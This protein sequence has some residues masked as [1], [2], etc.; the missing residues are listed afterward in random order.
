MRRDRKL[1]LIYALCATL[2]FAMAGADVS[3]AQSGGM[4][5]PAIDPPGEPFSYFWHPNDTIGA[6]F[7]P[8]ATEVT[9]EGYLYTGFGELIFFVGNPIE[10]V[11]KRIKTLYKGYLPIVQY[12]FPF[13]G[14]QYQFRMF[15]ADLGAGLTGLPVNFIEVKLTN[16]TH[17]Q[18]AAFLTSAFRFMPP[19]RGLNDI[20]EY[21]F[22]QRFDFIPEKY[23]KGQS[24]FSPE[25]KYSF[26]NNAVVRD[27]RILYLF[28]TSPKPHQ[29]A[30]APDDTGLRALRYFTGQ[31][32]DNPN[33][34]YTVHPY[35]P[36]GLVMY[37]IRLNPG[38]SQSLTFKF[39]IVPLPQDS[40][41]AEQVKSA[42][43]EQQ[44]QKTVQVWDNLVAKSVPLR[45]PE[46]KVQEYLLANTVNDIFA[47]DK[48]GD[49]FIPTDNKFQYH[50]S[51]AG[52][53]TNFM[54]IGFDY[55]GLHDIARNDLLYS[56]KMQNSEGAFV[57]PDGLKPGSQLD[58]WDS[59]G[60]TLFGWGRHYM[61]TRDDDFLRRVYPAVLRAFEW[62][63]K[64]VQKD[65][66]GLMPPATITDDAMLKDARQTGH[67]LWTMIGLRNAVRMAEAMTKPED[68][69]RFDAEYQRLRAAFDKQLALQTAKSGGYIPP[70][71]E[72]TLD[73]NDWDNMLLLHPEPL[74]EPF[75]P[76]VT[77]TLRKTRSTYAEGILDYLTQWAVA[78]E[79]W[80][81]DLG[82]MAE[83]A[84]RGQGYIFNNR[85]VLHY[86]HTPTNAGNHL[87]RGSAEDQELAVRDMYSMLLHSTSTHASQEFGSVPWSTRDNGGYNLLPDVPSS[88]K[89][90]DL[91]RNMLVREYK[92][93]LYLLSALSPSWFKPGRIIE[94]VDE[95]TEF[96][97]ISFWSRVNSDLD[98]WGWTVKL[99]N[100]FRRDPARILVRIPWFY[101]VQRAEA[102]G[103]V[104]EVKDG[105]VVLSVDTKELRFRGRT[106]PAASDMSF[107]TTVETYKKEYRK[108]YEDFLRTG[109]TK[110]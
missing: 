83:G 17:E 109:V 2:A 42:D 30:L 15:G 76:R 31:I 101:Q 55:M 28:P 93:D 89:T 106:N 81:L 24:T 27:G 36:L 70:A 49:D 77:A 71:M 1:T 97:P 102:D 110:P 103:H 73:G 5:D 90:I 45:F 29:F 62:E 32:R 14:V 104:I 64:M 44:F 80:P 43:Y 53:D 99:S 10:P 91:L 37:R 105:H 52:L 34:T 88:S 26:A 12:Q 35:T 51:Q 25:W 92:N 60:G 86:W 46:Q 96:G 47:I 66:L 8:V 65:T 21:R 107:E 23:V 40:P 3:F 48:I 20:A 9:P 78:R 87:V 38:E 16:L 67:Q 41:E 94:V 79:D 69:K 18:R 72:H 50:N 82:E 13:N 84:Q 7:A 95:P 59:F 33:P 39:P 74:F 108:R 54:D 68:A 56:L 19:I 58:Y 11:N 100:R 98:D 85:S 4:L 6:P 57:F 61:L 22:R 63:Q 75:D